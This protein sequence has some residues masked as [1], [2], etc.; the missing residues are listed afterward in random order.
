MNNDKIIKQW[1]NVQLN[2]LFYAKYFSEKMTHSHSKRQTDFFS[3]KQT[4]AYQ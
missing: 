1:E 2:I 4:I 3:N